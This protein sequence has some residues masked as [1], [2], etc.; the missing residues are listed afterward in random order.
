MIVI[1]KHNEI[2][3]ESVLQ[4]ADFVVQSLDLNDI[5]SFKVLKSRSKQVDDNLTF[6]QV[7]NVILNYYR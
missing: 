5:W 7:V 3:E 4:K 6:T 1:Y 2:P